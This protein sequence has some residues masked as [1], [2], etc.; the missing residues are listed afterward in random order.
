[1][2]FTLVSKYRTELMGI[3]TLWVMLFHYGNINIPII[4]NLRI[5]GYGG[6]DIFLFLSGIGL[7]F[8]IKGGVKS[9]YIT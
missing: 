1:M 5:I 4:D 3:A 8:S 2:N 9:F 6:V 7:S